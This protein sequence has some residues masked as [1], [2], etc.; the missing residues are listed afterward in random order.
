MAAFLLGLGDKLISIPLR[1]HAKISGYEI[2]E[3]L[4][5]SKDGQLVKK[6]ISFFIN[7]KH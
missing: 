5:E 4:W 1:T 3:F 2:A 6:T 7:A